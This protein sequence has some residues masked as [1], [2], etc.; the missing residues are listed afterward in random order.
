M[1][2]TATFKQSSTTRMT[3]R[4][5]YDLL[6]RIRRVEP[7]STAA[8][9]PGISFDSPGARKAKMEGALN[10][11]LSASIHRGGEPGWVHHFGSPTC[12]PSRP[13]GVHAAI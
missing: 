12:N 3:T 10:P 2:G 5:E 7:L 11:R 13:L 4:R 8:N 9:T 1:P 6:S